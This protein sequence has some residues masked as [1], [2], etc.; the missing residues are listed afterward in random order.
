MKYLFEVCANS[1]TSAVAAQQGGAHRI[2]LCENLMQGGTTPSYGTILQTR[3]LLQIPIHVLIR[4]RTGDFLYSDA[5]FEVMKNDILLCKD[6]KID[7]IVSGV[8]NADGTIDKIRTKE[9]VEHSKPMTFTFHRAIDVSKNI[10]DALEDCIA[11]GCDR[12]L[13]SGSENTA[14][15]GRQVIKKLVNQANGKIIIMVGSGVNPKNIRQIASE[16]GAT[17]FHSSA[18]RNVESKMIYRSAKVNMS[19]KP[20]DEFLNIETDS[21]IVKEILVELEKLCQSIKL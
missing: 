2:E 7:G 3:K 12:I 13:T 17:E 1:V 15:D 6:L 8:L 14:Y 4:P 21:E 10:F 16:T 9:L 19:A 5:E 18:K 11:I 20:M